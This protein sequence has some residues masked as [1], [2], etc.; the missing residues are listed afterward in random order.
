VERVTIEIVR[1]AMR[2]LARS[3][4]AARRVLAAEFETA[5]TAY[6]ACRLEP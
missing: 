3:A 1:A 4:P 5:V 2:R 6:L